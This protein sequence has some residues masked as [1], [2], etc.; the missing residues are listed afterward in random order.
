MTMTDPFA[1]RNDDNEFEI[2]LAGASVQIEGEFILMCTG[3]M[4]DISQAGS[5]MWVFDFQ[6]VTDRKGGTQFAGTP[7]KCWAVTTA[8]AMWKV[9]E[10][11]VALGLAQP[12][13]KAKFQKKDCIGRMILGVI[14]MADFNGRPRP[15]IK[16][17]APHPLAPGYRGGATPMSGPAPQSALGAAPPPAQQAPV[18][19][20]VPA[21]APASAPAQAAKPKTRGQR[22][23]VPAQPTCPYRAGQVVA[24]RFNDNGTVDIFEAE[25]IRAD[26]V[27][28]ILKDDTNGEFAVSP[29]DVGA[30]ENDLLG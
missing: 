22:P 28:Y 11:L 12:G 9:E 20:A 30:T 1:E 24:Y 21:T 4:K 26:G 15:N 7:L 27:N 10:V 17:M 6:V 13:G 8:A 5:P 16:L 18:A 19:A 3:L 23:A 25:F 14:E 29:L 2:D